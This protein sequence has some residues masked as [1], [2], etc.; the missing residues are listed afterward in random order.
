MYIGI[1]ALLTK[2]FVDISTADIAPTYA[3]GKTIQSMDDVTVRLVSENV[4]I[5]IDNNVAD[6]QCE[7]NL[8]NEGPPD[9]IEVGFPQYHDTDDLYDFR[10]EANG[11]VFLVETK[12]V[13]ARDTKPSDKKMVWWKTFSI[14]FDSTGQTVTVKISYWIRLSPSRRHSSDEYFMYVLKTG[15]FWKG[16]IQEATFTVTLKNTHFEQLTEIN[17]ESYS[18]KENEI[19]WHNKDFEPTKNIEIYIMQDMLI[20]PSC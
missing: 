12:R 7:F 14:P 3:V 20:R 11:K 19:I 4:R 16:N 10:A 1:A 13:N 17:P 9:I 6:V 2:G 8:L 18:R 5:V 15:A